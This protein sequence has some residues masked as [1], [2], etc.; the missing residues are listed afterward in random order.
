MS[1]ITIG[2]GAFIGV[3]DEPQAAE[4]LAG[5]LR[6]LVL[7]GQLS[8][9]DVLPSERALMADT[10]LSRATVREAL[11][12]LEI[13]ALA[14]P[15]LGRYGG[16]TIRRPDR[17]QVTRSIDGFIRGSQVHLPHLLATREAI[18][19]SCA[20]LAAESR[21]EADL[22]TL[23][24]CG[25]ELRANI[26]DLTLYLQL[27][28]RWHLAVVDATH[29]DLLIAVM[30]ALSSAVYDGTEIEHVNSLPVRHEVATAH[31]AVVEAIRAGDA[32]AARRRMHRHVRAFRDRAAPLGS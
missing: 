30:S 5:R 4:V 12:K 31:D 29:N 14:T 2:D 20:A 17:E 18:E 3:I 10:G 26:D 32:D 15:S 16:W 8:A 6:Q 9:G 27:N 23:D 19:P 13:E 1:R 7:G 25:A 22:A 28:L 24:E 11:R 21:T